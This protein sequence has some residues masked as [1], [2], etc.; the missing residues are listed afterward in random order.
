MFLVLVRAKFVSLL[1]QDV[2]CF[3]INDG[4]AGFVTLQKLAPLRDRY[5][6]L[7]LTCAKLYHW[8]N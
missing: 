6:M 3:K 5:V 4:I 8:L 1:R 7:N 2:G